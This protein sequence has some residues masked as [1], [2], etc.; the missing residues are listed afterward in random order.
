MDYQILLVLYSSYVTNL[1]FMRSIAGA[2]IM[3]GS[4]SCIY[5]WRAYHRDMVD[6]VCYD[7]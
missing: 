3:I 1:D 6:A 5:T 7:C 2:M 4:I